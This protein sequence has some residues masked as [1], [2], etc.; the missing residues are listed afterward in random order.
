MNKA[1][2]LKGVT[3]LILKFTRMPIGLVARLIED[4]LLVTAALLKILLLVEV[5]NIVVASSA[6][7]E[8]GAPMVFV[9]V[10][11]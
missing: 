4:S 9:K 7:A 1:Y 6:E 3:I 10:Y 11:R 8:F 5:K 2:C